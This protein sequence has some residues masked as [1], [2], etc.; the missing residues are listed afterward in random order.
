M[1]PGPRRLDKRIVRVNAERLVS[2]Y[3]QIVRHK[4]RLAEQARGSDLHLFIEGSMLQTFVLR[5][6][7]LEEGRV[8]RVDDQEAHGVNAS[9]ESLRF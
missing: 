2:E 9:T 3:S 8:V 4:I 5:I 6:E 1:L 7:P